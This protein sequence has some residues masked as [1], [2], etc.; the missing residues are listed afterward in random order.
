MTDEI[1]KYN[2]NLVNSRKLYF[3]VTP[4]KNEETNLP[5]IIAT[6]ERQSI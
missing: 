1:I 2:Q 4:I 3:L 6:V 5:N